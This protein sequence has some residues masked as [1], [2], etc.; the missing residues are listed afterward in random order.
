MEGR[1]GEPP[2]GGFYAHSC[3]PAGPPKPAPGP[4]TLG[5]GVEDAPP[6]TPKKTAREGGGGRNLAAKTQSMRTS[7]LKFE[8]FGLYF[9]C[10]LLSLR[11]ISRPGENLGSQ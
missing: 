10:A 8:H 2:R 7:I 6:P 9:D 5:R 1:G 4:Q 3:A 11:T